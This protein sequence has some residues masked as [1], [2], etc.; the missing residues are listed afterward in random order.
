[1][2]MNVQFSKKKKKKKKKKELNY[3]EG[4][5]FWVQ[6]W[7]TKQNDEQKVCCKRAEHELHGSQSRKPNWKQ[8]WNYSNSSSLLT[9]TP[10][11]QRP[12]VIETTP[13]DTQQAAQPPAHDNVGVK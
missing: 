8:S 1:M 12:S 6:T 3:P 11:N 7:P 13:T 5:V 4:Y 2:V 9:L 10:V